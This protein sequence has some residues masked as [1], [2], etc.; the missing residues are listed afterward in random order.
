MRIILLPIY[1][2]K[3][4]YLICMISLIWVMGCSSFSP[5]K[6]ES[7]N[8]R[9]AINKTFPNQYGKVFKAA[10]AA[11]SKYRL[12]V[13][14][15]ESGVLQTNYILRESVWLPPHEKQKNK[16][17]LRNQIKIVVL[18]GR[19]RKHKNVTQ[20]TIHKDISQKKNFFEPLVPIPSDGLEELSLLYRIERELD[21]ERKIN[22][23]K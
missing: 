15:Y 13:N 2:Q 17:R 9:E 22:R 11:L 23:L 16:N 20:V 4:C 3:R 21:I 5:P 10:R 18:K 12:S 19:S 6:A 8:H 1:F 7:E 14:D